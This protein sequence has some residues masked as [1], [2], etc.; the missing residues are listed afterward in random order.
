MS[1]EILSDLFPENWHAGAVVSECGLYRYNLWRLWDAWPDKC[2]LYRYNLWQLWDAWPDK[3]P[4]MVFVMQNPSTA[5][6]DVDD[7]TIRR[8]IGFA[9]REG[10]GGIEVRNVFA[11]RATDERELPKAEDPVGPYNHEW[12]RGAAL[13][14]LP[15]G[16]IVVAWGNRTGG[17]NLSRRYEAAI[18]IL[19]NEELWCLGKTRDGNPRHPLMLPSDAKLERWYP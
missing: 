12:I 15:K 14:A 11:L 6:A 13:A 10:C 1:I 4:R 9:K 7:P 19:A 3:L 8:C 2:A 5:S 17:K 16:R 18:E